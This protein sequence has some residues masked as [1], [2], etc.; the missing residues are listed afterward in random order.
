MI[1][2]IV[3]LAA[4]AMTV[5]EQLV[6]GRRWSRV[7]GWWTRALLLNGAQAGLVFVAGITWEPWLRAHRP[8]SVDRLGT[9]GGALIGYLVITFVY[10]W[11]HRCRH[12]V[13]VLWR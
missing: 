6:P 5:V 12:A 3:L 9:V 4:V 8:W 10:Y 7:R 11:W 1:P 13:P 2:L